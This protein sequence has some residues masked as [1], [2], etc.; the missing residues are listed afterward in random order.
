MTFRSMACWLLPNNVMTPPI[1]VCP[2]KIPTGDLLQDVRDVQ[3]LEHGEVRGFLA[4][5]LAYLLNERRPLKRPLVRADRDEE[6]MK[7]VLAEASI[8]RR[9]CHY[10]NVAVAQCS[11][12]VYGP[13][14]SQRS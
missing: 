11:T 2:S 13:G 8:S 12:G 4:V 1:G 5:L 7:P 14:N 10:Q 6:G 9:C 3:Y